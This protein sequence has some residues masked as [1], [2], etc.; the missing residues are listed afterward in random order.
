LFTVYLRDLTAECDAECEIQRRR[1]APQ[2]SEK[3]AVFSSLLAGAAH[4]L[5]NRSPS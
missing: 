5:N 2:R 4:D 3:M 1:E